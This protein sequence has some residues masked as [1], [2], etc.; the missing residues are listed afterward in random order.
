MRSCAVGGRKMAEHWRHDVMLPSPS[1]WMRVTSG[2]SPA[3]CSAGRTYCTTAGVILDLQTLSPSPD[4]LS[5]KFCGTLGAIDQKKCLIPPVNK[6]SALNILKI[7]TNVLYLTPL[8]TGESRDSPDSLSL[9]K[10]T[11]ELSS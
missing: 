5:T 8:I 3:R 10:Y 9:R 11:L 7:T 6:D 1:P 4:K 2:Q